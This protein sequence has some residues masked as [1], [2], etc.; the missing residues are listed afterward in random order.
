MTVSKNALLCLYLVLR[1]STTRQTAVLFLIQFGSLGLSC[2]SLLNNSNLPALMMTSLIA[3]HD[4]FLDPS[5]LL[6]AAKE[7]V[8]YDVTG[9]L[10]RVWAL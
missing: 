3:F 10:L 1:D 8:N 6:G 2:R 7:D 4:V 5:G 9:Q